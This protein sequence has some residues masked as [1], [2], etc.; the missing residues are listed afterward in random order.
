MP[1][2]VVVGTQWGDEGKGKIIDLLTPQAHHIVRTQGGNNAGHTLVINGEEYKFHLIPSGI[3]HPHTRCYIGAGTVIDPKVLL[4][5]IDGLKKRGFDLRGRLLISSNA[6]VI[7]PYHRSLD[8]ALEQKKGARAIGTT[9]RGIGPCY[10]DKAHRIG[11]RMGE[12]CRSDLFPDILRSV[13]GFHEAFDDEATLTEYQEYAAQLS[14]YVCAVENRLHS[15]LDL[16]ETVLLE[17]A[18]GTFLDITHGTYPFVTSSNTIA[19][20]I[21]AGAGIGPTDVDHTLGIMKAYTTRVGNGPLPSEDSA[22][23]LNHTNSREVGTTTGRARRIGWFDAIMARTA[24]RLNGI[25]SLAITKLDI[26]DPLPTIKVCVGYKLK[27]ETIDYFP[28]LAEELEEVEPIYE[29]MPGWQQPTSDMRTYEQLPEEAQNY[30]ARITSL[31][32]APMSI[33]SLGP[34]RNQTI[35]LQHPL[36]EQV[37]V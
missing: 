22:V 17:G 20:G 8:L 23:L 18:Q 5:E 19:G 30:L 34:D 27:G 9:G 10:V 35:L 33:L 31:A 16:G 3:L 1:C 14:P 15:A 37:A 13:A 28:T 26:L 29:E 21:C 36:G 24:V 25:T 2:I 7:F 12:L 4:Q 6:H 11:I 32:G